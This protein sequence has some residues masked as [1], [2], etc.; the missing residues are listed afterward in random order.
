MPYRIACVCVAAAVSLAASI[1][2]AQ[3]APEPAASAPR[4]RVPSAVPEGTPPAATFTTG[5]AARPAAA[6]P[7]LLQTTPVQFTPQAATTATTAPAA[8]PAQGAASSSSAITSTSAVLDRSAGQIWREYD[9]SSYTSRV[10]N[11]ARPEQA[12]VDWILRETGTEVWF[13]EPLGLLS[14]GR[15]KLRVY[16]T[17]EMQ[18]IVADVV[19]RFLASQA[20]SHVLALRL[21]TV[22]SP[23]WRTTAHHLL[24]PVSV[25]TP[26]VDAWLLTKENAAILIAELSKRNDYIEH[27]SPNLLIHNGQSQFISRQRPRNYVR[28]VLLRENVA[29]YELEMGQVDEGY[30][31]ELSPLISADS[32]TIDA[33][34]R[35]E[36]NQVESLVPVM[37]DVPTFNAQ[38]Q[39][40]Q[41]Q[42]PQ[43]AS[44]QLHERFRW[45]ADHVLL[46]GAGVGAT[47]TSERPT[48]LGVPNLL[49]IGPPRADGLLFIES[50]GKASQSVI[51]A[52]R[53]TRVDSFHGRY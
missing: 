9:I 15:D 25:Q 37:I 38:R 42:V 35:C 2:S 14:A 32:R 43:M 1:V 13:S 19:D 50:K 53:N 51:E 39:R 7:T 41:I 8:A 23:N 5:G 31:L 16:H 40:V 24:K 34:I 52:A 49:A 47:P 17:P 44:R 10:T 18:L 12:L 6:A 20:E 46:I 45:P 33:V 26:G 28:G 27:N 48:V 36:V 22:G 3:V 4:F 21:V 29:G 11:T 30:S